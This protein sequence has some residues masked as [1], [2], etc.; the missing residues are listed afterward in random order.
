MIEQ[1][2]ARGLK[3]FPLQPNG[4]RPEAK[5]WQQWATSASPEDILNYTP[6]H[7]WGV[8]C[9][10]LIVLDIDN[11]NGK[12]GSASLSELLKEKAVKLPKTFVVKT[13]TG[14]LHYYYK[15]VGR[16]RANIR[17]GIDIRGDGGFVVAPG[18]KINNAEYKVYDASPIAEAPQWL[19]DLAIERQALQIDEGEYIT[20]GSRNETLARIAGALRATG[21]EYEHILPS[22]TAFNEDRIAPPLPES[23]VENIARSICRYAPNQ[24]RGASDFLAPVKGELAAT[25]SSININALPKRDWV[26]A[27]RYL[28]GFVTAIVSPG[29][30]GKSTLVMLEA[31]SIATGVDR[32][33]C[34]VI[35]PGAVW[36]YNTEDAKEEIDRR[37]A[38]MAIHHKIDV[39]ELGNVHVTSGRDNPLILAKNDPRD[40]VVVNTEAIDRVS[41][42]ILEHKIVWLAVDPFVRTH[43][44]SEN[45]NMQIDKV[46]WAFQR[47]IDKTGVAVCLVHHTGK[48]VKGGQDAARGASAFINATRVA[49]TVRSMEESEALQLGVHS[50][51]A[52][53]Y[54]R[55]DSAKANLSPPSYAADWYRRVSVKLPNGDSVGAIE[56]AELRDGAIVGTAERMEIRDVANALC[57]TMEPGQYLP[58]EIAYREVIDQCIYG[59]SFEHFVDT[60]KAGVSAEGAEF[61]YKCQPEKMVVDW[62]YRC[63]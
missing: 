34:K 60:C 27:G 44:V 41:A 37:L 46:V 22:L 3:L 40:G 47:I 9:R 58:L 32:V 48:S 35:K 20:E 12:N 36:L 33:G 30:I 43:E 14:G 1:L 50:E 17:E 51:D 54:L 42:Y 2:L 55:M 26:L 19:Y 23:E 8:F 38:A 16:N 6:G 63:Q 5:D 18:S 29:G 31:L 49:F 11:K 39:S 15:G 52:P 62:L 53:W 45:D 13:P 59:K 24:A 25:A 4:K 57:N 10:G 21:L 7:N 28:G 56:R 61:V